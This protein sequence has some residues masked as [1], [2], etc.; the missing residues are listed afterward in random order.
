MMLE[1]GSI[2]VVY[3]L[4]NRCKLLPESLSITDSVWPLPI[5]QKP[6]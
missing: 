4:E 5:R 3:L 6:G 1:D 2:T